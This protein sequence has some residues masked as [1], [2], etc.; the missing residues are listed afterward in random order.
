MKIVITGATG[1][2]G[3]STL[4]SL[5]RDARVKEVVAI[6]RRKPELQ[7]PRTR[8]VAAD[9]ASADLMPFFR[10]ADAVIHLAWLLQPS[11][12]PERLQRTNVEGSQRVFDAVVRAGV[13]SL[14]VSS[15]VGA[16]SPGPK[17]RCV[18]ESWPTDGIRSSLYSV[19]K[20]TV[21]RQLDALEHAHPEL[22]VVRM[23]PALVF[24]RGAAAEI[25]R[26]FIGPFVPRFL[27]GRNRLLVPHVDRLRF[28]CVHSHDVGRAF[29]M[30]ALSQVDGAFNIA[31]YPILDADMI[32]EALHAR[33]VTVS[34]K[35][36][37]RA[38]S[39][40]YA[41]HLTPT[42]PGWLELALGAPL[43]SIDRARDLLGW[44]PRRNASAALLDLVDG[45]RQGTG[46]ATAPLH[47]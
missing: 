36:L 24:K 46:M 3:T 34:E 7:I 22:R 26:L 29:A 16:Y 44:E 19:Q 38:V 15:S 33:R 39:A 35:F 47:S 4:R 12:E 13:P 25:R 30:A 31:T 18:D 8:F 23:R 28:Q 27:F 17:D 9:V 11:R 1:N 10:G 20:A 37:Q 45:L 41:M 32:A 40:A 21:E 14:I 42:D 5:A 43:M 2:I 6:A